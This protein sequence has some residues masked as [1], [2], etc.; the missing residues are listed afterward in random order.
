MEDM[1]LKFTKIHAWTKVIVTS[2]IQSN[3]V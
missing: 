1:G 2:T 3:F